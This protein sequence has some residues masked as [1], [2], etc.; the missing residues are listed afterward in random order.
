MTERPASRSLRLAAWSV[1]GLG[2]ALV[3]AALVLLALNARSIHAGRYEAGAAKI[4][5]YAF[6]AVAVIVY[7]AVGAL[8]AVRIQRNAIGWLL[9]FLGGALGANLFLEQLGVWGLATSPGSIPALKQIV[10]FGAATQNLTLAPLILLLLLFPDGRLPSRRW[11]PVLW[12]GIWVVIVAGFG[13][14]LQRGIAISGGFTNALADAHLQF[15]N[16]L[17]VFPRTGWYSDVLGVTGA[18][19]VASAAL[20]VVSVFV[21]RRRASPERRQQLAW[22]GYVGAAF[23]VMAAV[24]LTY[25]AI[26]HGGNKAVSTLLFVLVFGIPIFGIPVA[27]AVAVLKYRLYDLDVAVKR[28]VVF[29]VLAR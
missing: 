2:V 4:G 8:I 18:L 9:C 14:V 12:A 15:E 7:E 20:A 19:A 10:A 25:S 26:T 23:F 28:T 11:R 13:L 29:G 21:R 27:C 16:P 24:M 1:A 3:L 22:L 6:A 17:G 5:T